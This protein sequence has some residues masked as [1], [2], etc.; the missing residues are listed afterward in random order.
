MNNHDLLT[1]QLVLKIFHAV[2]RQNK[3]LEDQYAFCMNNQDKKQP[4]ENRDRMFVRLLVTV[5]LR[6][7]R[8]S[9]QIISRFL[10]SPLPEKAFY[11][12]DILRLGTVQLVFLDTPPHAAVSTGVSLIKKNPEYKGF[13]GLVNAVLHRI[14][15]QGKVIARN[16]DDALINVPDWLYDEWRKEYGENTAKK[17]AAA[18]LHEAPVDF[19]VKEN[20]AYWADQLQAVEM[21]TKTLRRQ[22]TVA[23]PTLPGFQE[24]NWW[25]QDLSAAIPARLFHSLKGKNA[26][27]ICA[28]PGGKTAQ[29]ITAGANVT[30]IDISSN[31]IDRLKENLNRL[32]LQANLVCADVSEWWKS[33]KHQYQKFDAVLL[34]APCS[35]TGTLRRHP[36]VCVHRTFQDI[37]RLK[38][39]QESLLKTAVDML[40]DTGEL[41]YCVCSILPQ[42]GREI[43]DQAVQ[44]G[45]VERMALTQQDVPKEMITEQGDLC[46]FP[47]FY[48]STG[49]CDGFYAARLKKG[50]SNE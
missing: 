19:S 2:L 6:R 12:Q 22:K 33:V 26:I 25:V 38:K 28:A 31:R 43:I 30:A 15:E 50:K 4:L 8:Q 21:P 27:D 23:I 34:D 39:T 16:Q 18:G 11:V 7:L 3:G 29:L 20:H 10:K 37:E 32:H 40:S 24:G 42:E 35:A 44:S 17:I 13:S 36:D 41:I 48:E 5:M 45:S 9:D 46:I 14:A 49:G 47:F 1:R